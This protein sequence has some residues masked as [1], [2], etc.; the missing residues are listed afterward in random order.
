MGYKPRCFQSVF[1]DSFT[2]ER[3][4]IRIPIWAGSS[5]LEAQLVG[6]VEVPRNS[7]FTMSLSK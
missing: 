2:A 6:Q 3:R 5:S 4:Q 1:I 7:M